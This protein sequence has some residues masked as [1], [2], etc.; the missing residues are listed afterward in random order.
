MCIRDSYKEI[1]RPEWFL[2]LAA[3]C[4]DTKFVMAGVIPP[5]PLT[6]NYF[7]IACVAAR[8]LTNLEVRGF[9]SD[10]E[11]AEL[12][13]RASLLVHTSPVEGFSNVILE[14]WATGLP[15]VSCVNPDEI[16]TREGL[17]LVVETYDEIL[18]EVRRLIANPAK[19]RE[20]GAR[21]RAYATTRHA[22]DAVIDRL[23]AI[24]D[25]V[26]A[27]VRARRAR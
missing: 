14:A 8:R 3:D 12:F 19:R 10:R 5:P 16:V 11:I 20:L 1:K 15:T 7:E 4:P 26:V 9:Q 22:P 2:R 17:G 24:L 6:R 21:A 18:A 27:D 25:R 23:A 13:H